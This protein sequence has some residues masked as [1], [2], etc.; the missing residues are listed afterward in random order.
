[1]KN[2]VVH[3]R[4]IGNKRENIRRER[5]PSKGINSSVWK[6]KRPYITDTR[7]PNREDSCEGIVGFRIPEKQLVFIIVRN[8]PEDKNREAKQSSGLV[9]AKGVVSMSAIKSKHLTN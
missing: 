9:Q 4:F 7:R 1:M 3:A 6:L 5:C 8:Q 2:I